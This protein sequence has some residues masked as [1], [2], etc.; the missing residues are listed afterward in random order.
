M[1]PHAWCGAT[2]TATNLGS[3]ATWPHYHMAQQISESTRCVETQLGSD[4]PA[5]PLLSR[6]DEPFDEASGTR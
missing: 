3:A 5:T 1:P 4:I 2:A 6:S